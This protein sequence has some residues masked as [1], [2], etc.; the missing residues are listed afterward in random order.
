MKITIKEIA[1]IA[2]VHRSTV[3]KVLHHREGV[4]DAVRIKVQKIIDEVGYESNP[5]GKALKHQKEKILLAAVLVKVDALTELQQGIQNAYT[6]YKNFNIEIQYYTIDY[7]QA[8]QQAKILRAL[9]LSGCSGIIVSPLDHPD[10]EA[11]LQE[12]HTANIPLVTLNID[13]RSK[14]SRLCFIGQ[15]M[16]KAGRTAARMADI[17]LEGRGRAAILGSSNPLLP[18]SGREQGFRNY[19]AESAPR[20]HIMHTIDTNENPSQAYQQTIA[21]LKNDPPDIIFAT[22]GCVA[23]I[24]N[25]LKTLP[26]EKRPYLICFERYPSIETLL[27]DGTITCTISSDLLTQGYEGIKYLFEFILFERRPS[28]D[29]FY[30][31]IGILLK[32]NL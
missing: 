10:V 2:N 3:D 9:A 28:Q 7:P 23:E 22:S 1:A 20:M 15:N 29:A 24:G 6:D 26:A 32:E 27:Q 16:E 21:L 31:P 18:V 11:A 25:A 13:C 19:M 8:E 5:L 30:M 14:A 17:L 4:S 12:L